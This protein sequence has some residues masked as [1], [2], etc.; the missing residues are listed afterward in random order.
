MTYIYIFVIIISETTLSH[1]TF[2]EWIVLEIVCVST[3]TCDLCG[4]GVCTR[5]Y[6]IFSLDRS[7][8][9][10]PPAAKGST[11][12]EDYDDTLQ[13]AARDGLSTVMRPA[14]KFFISY[15]MPTPQA[16]RVYR[17]TYIHD[18]YLPTWC[19]SLTRTN[20]LSDVMCKIM[21][22]FFSFSPITGLVVTYKLDENE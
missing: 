2:V 7:S 16:P 4:G 18:T 21:I 3:H 12:R 10:S 1:R 8:R 13:T 9:V 6:I 15:V 22:L 14:M 19:P 11:C 20:C 17:Y 5:E